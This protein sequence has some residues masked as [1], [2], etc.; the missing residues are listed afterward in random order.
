MKRKEKQ[1]VLFREVCSIIYDNILIFRKQ[2]K[3]YILMNLVMHVMIISKKARLTAWQLCFRMKWN[4][5][6]RFIVPVIAKTMKQVLLG[7]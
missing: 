4:W 2:L 7:Q 3:T 1:V 6:I 5:I